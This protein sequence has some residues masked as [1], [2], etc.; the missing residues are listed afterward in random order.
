[1]NGP[2]S[3]GK[4]DEE[5]AALLRE[6]FAE[7]ESQADQLPAAT[8]SAPN[9]D[10]GRARR[11]LS[12][13]VLAAAAVA[14]VL[15]AVI[16]VRQAAEPPSAVP[17]PAAS[18]TPEAGGPATPSA[19]T[20]STPA[21][22]T[23]EVRIWA[24]TIKGILERE[25]GT[26]PGAPVYVLDAPHQGAGGGKPVRGEPFTPAQQDAIAAALRPG[27]TL[28]WIAQRPAAD[29][30]CGPDAGGPYVMVGPIVRKDG[31]AEVG[32]N[33]WR[34]CLAARWLTFRLDQNAT[35]WRITGTVGPEAVA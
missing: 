23:D 33:I 32:V 21:P 24:A 12:P 27:V 35:D 13:V 2:H 11:R 28:K 18:S 16:I 3:N 22:T 34:G 5:L 1:M 7:R 14:L 31:H 9:A 17:L 19:G 30:P 26:A 10:P 20:A 29:D 25:P 6:T 4:T 8:S 15:G